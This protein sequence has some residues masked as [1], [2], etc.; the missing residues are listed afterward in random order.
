MVILGAV[1]H[2]NSVTVK[3]LHVKP[4]VTNNFRLIFLQNYKILPMMD[5]CGQP[6]LTEYEKS[7]LERSP[8]STLSIPGKS[9]EQ[10]R[11]RTFTNGNILYLIF[12]FFCPK[13]LFLRTKTAK[14]DWIR[15]TFLI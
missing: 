2:K 3:I 11:L 10:C 12:G 5:T 6:I 15:N 13:T 9:E 1:D 4:R 7:V 8:Y 14:K